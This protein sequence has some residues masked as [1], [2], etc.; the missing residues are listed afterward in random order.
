MGDLIEDLSVNCIYGSHS[1][2]FMN[3]LDR[4]GKPYVVICICP[5]HDD[6][7]DGG[8]REPRHPKD[9]TPVLSVSIPE[10]DGKDS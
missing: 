3:R 9:P 5:C 4:G 1:L 10:P 8:V 6:L 2:C 7:P